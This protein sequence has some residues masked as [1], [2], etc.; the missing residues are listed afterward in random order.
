MKA[1]LVSD[2]SRNGFRAIV[3]IE[4]HPGRFYPSYPNTK[5]IVNVVEASF[6]DLEQALKLIG[7]NIV[8]NNNSI[9]HRIAIKFKDEI[10]SSKENDLCWDE[11]SNKGFLKLIKVC[12]Q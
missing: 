2:I 4:N 9:L 8:A 7:I 10:C 3:E 5:K 11:R 6:T 1:S 12:S